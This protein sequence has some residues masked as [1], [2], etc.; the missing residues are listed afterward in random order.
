MAKNVS[1]KILMIRARLF[2]IFN[3][4]KRRP[5]LSRNSKNSGTSKISK[6]INET[7][8]EFMYVKENISDTIRNG[9]PQASKNSRDGNKKYRFLSPH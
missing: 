7:K 5:A 9:Q 6:E 8:H 4:K 2:N 1:H 3:F